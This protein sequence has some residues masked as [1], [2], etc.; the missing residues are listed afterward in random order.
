MIAANKKF[1][2]N[3]ANRRT[4]LGNRVLPVCDSYTE[5]AETHRN[6]GPILI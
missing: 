2:G 6:I 5:V 3:M 4:C 1:C